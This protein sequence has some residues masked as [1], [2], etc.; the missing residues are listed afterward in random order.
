M[1]DFGFPVSSLSQFA[2]PL[3]GIMAGQSP[4]SR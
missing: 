2:E 1:I 3:A 4:R